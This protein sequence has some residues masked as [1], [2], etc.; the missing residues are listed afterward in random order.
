[1]PTAFGEKSV[2]RI[3]DPDIVVKE[4]RQLGFAIGNKLANARG[5]AI[6]WANDFAGDPAHPDVVREQ[7]RLYSES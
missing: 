3:F 7:I 4:F 5:G 1:M 6:L 2:L